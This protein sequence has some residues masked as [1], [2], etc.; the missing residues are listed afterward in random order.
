M[1]GKDNA[2]VLELPGAQYVTTLQLQGGQIAPEKSADSLTSSASVPT[3]APAKALSRAELLASVV[4]PCGLTL[5]TV[6]PRHELTSAALADVFDW[7]ALIKSNAPEKFLK[8][9]P[10]RFLFDMIKFIGANNPG[11]LEEALESADWAVVGADK[12][13]KLDFMEKVCAF[14]MYFVFPP[15][16]NSLLDALLMTTDDPVHHEECLR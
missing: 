4:L 15:C 11:F 1:R 3:L 2:L 9:P 5:A 8:R 12:N 14:I 7:T 10:V 13:S 16:H 6:E